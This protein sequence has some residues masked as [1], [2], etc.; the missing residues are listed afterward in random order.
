MNIYNRIEY[1][2]NITYHNNRHW[3]AIEVAEQV[4]NTCCIMM[5]M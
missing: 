4:K 1:R 3:W 5:N 2:L